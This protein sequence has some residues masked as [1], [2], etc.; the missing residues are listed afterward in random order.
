MKTSPKLKALIERGSKTA[1]NGFRNEIDI[2]IK[3]DNWKQDHDAQDW[4]VEMGY[5]LAEI[6]KIETAILHGYKTDIQ[7]K[8]TIHFKKAISSENLSIKLVSNPQGFNQIDKRRVEKYIEMW[9]IPEE[10]ALALRK[11]TGEIIPT[12]KDGL[13]DE[14]RIFF[15]EMAL[16]LQEKIKR[17][18]EQN[19]ILIISDLLQGR[20]LFPAQW[21]MVVLK[22]GGVVHWVLKP[23]NIVMNIYGNGEVRITDKGNLKIGKIGMQ[24]KGGDNG[25]DSAKM[26]QFKINPVELFDN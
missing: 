15:N 11:F 7:V 18:F 23:I 2:A 13:R 5:N 25:R 4:L 24:R 10:I 8:I 3:F 9:N 14:R 1:R 16:D 22:S 6:E 26:L 20:D 21:M 12:N 17:F 19:K